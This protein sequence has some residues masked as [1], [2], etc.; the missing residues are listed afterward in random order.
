MQKEKTDRILY[1]D[2]ISF[3]NEGKIHFQKEFIT[4]R[5]AK[6][7]MLKSVLQAKEKYQI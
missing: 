6:Q 3:K 1:L 5:P 2:K 4:V 7:K